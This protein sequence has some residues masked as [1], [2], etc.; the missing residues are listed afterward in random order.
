MNTLAMRSDDHA[1]DPVETTPLIADRSEPKARGGCCGK[2][3]DWFGSIY[4]YVYCSHTLSAWGD[5]MWQF[6]VGLFLVNLTGDSLQL[7]A[8]YG[9]SS[10]GSVLL[11]GAL[12]GDWVDRNPR[13]QARTTLVIQNLSIIICAVILCMM[14]VY[15]DAMTTVWDGWLNTLCQALVI[16]FSDVAFLAST[17]NTIAIER[18]WVVEICGRDTKTLTK[19]TAFLRRID[20]TT[21]ILAPVGVGQIMTYGSLFIGA[22]FIAAWNFISFFIEYYL[23]WKVY[24]SVPALAIKKEKPKD[25]RAKED[26]DRTSVSSDGVTDVY[27]KRDKTCPDICAKIFG[28]FITLYKGWRCYMGQSVR[29]AGVAL[30]CLYMTV[31]GFD[32]ITTGYAYSQGMTESVLGIMMALGAIAGILGTFNFQFLRG[33][34]GLVRTGLISLVL[35]VSC[36]SLCVGSIWAPGSAF[37][38]LNLM[39]TPTSLTINCTDYRNTTL[40]HI[41]PPQ[42]NGLRYLSND[43]TDMYEFTPHAMGPVVL[44]ETPAKR[45]GLNAVGFSD[46]AKFSAAGVVN[47]TCVNTTSTQLSERN[48]L[49]LGLLMAGIIT[50]RFGLWSADLTI[51]QLI[52]ESVKDTERGTVNGVQSSINMLMDMLKFAMVIVA[53]DPQQFGILILISFVFII[54]GIFCYTLYV[55]QVRGHVFHFV[56]YFSNI[57]DYTMYHRTP[58]SRGFDVF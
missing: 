25:G 28:S 20:L 3:G 32:N 31:L 42:S 11:F 5:R 47:Y 12:I 10:G 6:A 22:V 44:N 17:G 30:S 26:S 46:G 50:A 16:F 19:M 14:L 24:Q 8:I 37:D 39:K 27:P 2:L 56:E 7:T 4:F 49:S 36:L 38:P 33:Q 58:G 9:F 23:L 51:T 40:F 34:V 43:H 29:F 21:N 13:L 55:K 52:M 53:P 18:D 57:S 41:S 54:V 1:G 35:E 15:P 45:T 48:F